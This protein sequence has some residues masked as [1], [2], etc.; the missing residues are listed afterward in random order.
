M[1]PRGTPTARIPTRPEKPFLERS[2]VS[3]EDRRS[4]ELHEA[5]RLVQEERNL[6]LQLM[7][8]RNAQIAFKAQGGPEARLLDSLREYLEGKSQKLPNLRLQEPPKPIPGAPSRTLQS[9]DPGESSKK[10][11][12]ESSQ[13]SQ[14]EQ[15]FGPEP[16]ES[17]KPS[18]SAIRRAKEKAKLAKKAEAT[19]TSNKAES[20]G[21][22]QTA[23][24]TSSPE[25]SL[26]EE[27][28][29]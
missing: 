12:L 27:S 22:K 23:T 29:K 11:K 16:E 18:K 25:K 2:P 14:L 6:E 21:E 10:R 8:N 4:R 24:Q 15:V 1:D 19:S 3:K 28:E 7:A 13:V 9:T 5:H 20:E 26:R 17:K